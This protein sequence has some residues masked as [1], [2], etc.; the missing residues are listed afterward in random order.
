MMSLNVEMTVWL[1]LK[2]KL[3]GE[4]IRE[5]FCFLLLSTEASALVSGLHKTG[6]SSGENINALPRE[7]SGKLKYITILL[8]IRLDSGASKYTDTVK[9]ILIELSKLILNQNRALVQQPQT[10]IEVL[11]SLA[12]T[13]FARC[14]RSGNTRSLLRLLWG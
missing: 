12:S 13:T 6:A 2:L 8:G 5:I 14:F 7:I 1:R 10:L 4:S 3:N 11:T 9:P